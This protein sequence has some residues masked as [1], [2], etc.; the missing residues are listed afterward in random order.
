MGSGDEVRFTV[1]G[2]EAF[3]RLPER[4]DDA[5]L[6]WVWFA[7]VVDGQPSARHDHLSRAILAAGRAFAGVSVGESYGSPAGREV[8]TAFHAEVTQRFGLA[9]RVTL[10]AQSRGGLQ[11]YAWASEHPEL[12]RRIGGI[13][14]VGDLRDWPGLER[15][16]PAYGLSPD[17]LDRQL[18]AH[19]PL[20]VLE[21]LARAGV[22]V[23]HVHGD[24]DTVVPHPAHTEKLAARYRELGGPVEVEV[25]PGFGHEEADVFFVNARLVSFLLH[26]SPAAGVSGS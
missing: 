10:L 4:R 16:A 5:P 3:V 23:F 21:P 26:G 9:G 6:D 19:N 17:E 13:Y 25:V 14:P 15:A 8:F 18:A 12:V 24:S 7:P 2:H 11:H 22:P 20:E 1:R